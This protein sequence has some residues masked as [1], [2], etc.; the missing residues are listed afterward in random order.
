MLKLT[1][2]TVDVC[3]CF[4]IL[5]RLTNWKLCISNIWNVENWKWVVH[6]CIQITFWF[7]IH[8]KVDMMI[9]Q[10]N[11]TTHFITKCW[12]VRSSQFSIHIS[13]ITFATLDVVVRFMIPGHAGPF[14]PCFVLKLVQI[15]H[16]GG[17]GSLC[18]HTYAHS[19]SVRIKVSNGNRNIIN[20]Y[21][22]LD[23]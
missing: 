21:T 8:F 6:E 7:V 11:W 17:V 19:I 10:S 5:K 18:L 9:I 4:N 12:N 22:Y 1:I 3:A 14:P 23:T 2:Q 13:L 15:K 20:T 16:S